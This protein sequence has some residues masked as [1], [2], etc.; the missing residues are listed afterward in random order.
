M[1]RNITLARTNLEL[2]GAFVDR[3]SA[4]C[5]WVK[6]TSGT[7]ALIQFQKNKVPVDDVEFAVDLL[8][9]TK[10]LFMAASPCFG[11][12]KDFKGFVRL[13]YA[14]HTEVLR[15]GL[16]KLGQYIERNLL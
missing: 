4:V 9:R 10:V 13:G 15:Q 11:S 16:E 14:C 12:G 7:T 2:L 8:S 1:K 6:P 3:Y 5:S